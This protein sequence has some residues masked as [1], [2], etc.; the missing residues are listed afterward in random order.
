MSSKFKDINIKNHTYYFFND[1]IN[2][3]FFDPNNINIVENSYKNNIVIYYIVY[4]NI[5]D[6]KCIKIKSVTPLYIIVNKVNGYFEEFNGNRYLM[7][8]IEAKQKLKNMKNCG[9]KAE[10][11]LGQ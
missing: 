5:K 9:V 11:Q 3:R 6:L 4:V 10:I 7:V 2:I 1:T 8:L